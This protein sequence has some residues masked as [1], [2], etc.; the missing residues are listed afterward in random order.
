MY[1]WGD[2]IIYENSI[3][4][5]YDIKF[6]QSR[7][8]YCKSG[9]DSDV[10]VHC[11][12]TG[13]LSITGGCLLDISHVDDA[14][15]Y[16]IDA[17]QSN[18]HHLFIDRNETGESCE[19]ICEDLSM[20]C[21]NVGY[22]NGLIVRNSLNNSCMNFD[23]V[24]I[25]DACGA[26]N[27]KGS[28]ICSCEFLPVLDDF[29]YLGVGQCQGPN[30]EIPPSYSGTVTFSQCKKTCVEEDENCLA[31]SY[32]SSQMRCDLWF[33]M[34][35]DHELVGFSFV[36]GSESWNIEDKVVETSS[37]SGWHCYRRNHMPTDVP[38]IV[39][40][41]FPTVQPTATTRRPSWSRPTRMPTAPP[42]EATE[43]PTF[44][45]PTRRPT[46]RPTE[47]PT[48]EPSHRPSYSKPTRK[49]TAY[50]PQLSAYPSKSPSGR[51]SFTTSKPTTRPTNN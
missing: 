28:F 51:P 17:D 21:V 25:E 39:P 32:L 31:I 8:G 34:P 20:E 4:T 12:E 1:C 40:T 27:L 22:D 44:S 29:Y 2:S 41:E 42:V 38:T 23:S 15:D 30:D 47:E 37:D 10:M 13:E 5:Y 19:E 18:I 43:G 6:G 49:P 26:R 50:R 45:R 14:V 7:N 11:S 48:K 3:V 9:F 16:C 36:D 35:V 33:D 46:S 24:D